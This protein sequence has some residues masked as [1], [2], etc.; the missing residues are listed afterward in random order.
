M[1]I[2]LINSQNLRQPNTR[3]LR[4]LARS[5]MQRA[6]SLDPRTEWRSVSL[7]LTDDAGIQELNHRYFGRDAATDVI[8]FRLDPIPGEESAVS[9]DIAVNVQRALSAGPRRRGW[10]ASTE[11][12]L[13]VAHGCD[14]LA[15]AT[16]ATPE[17]MRRMRRRELRWLREIRKESGEIEV[18]V[19]DVDHGT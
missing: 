12:A 3:G 13:Y 18:L 5:L 19:E 2:A 7:V 1:K 8:S 4:N 9:G 11:L 10:D 17:A 6:R 15:G 14:H 16:D